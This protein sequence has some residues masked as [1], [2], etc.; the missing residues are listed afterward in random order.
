M[1]VFYHASPV[2]G[3]TVLKPSNRTKRRRDDPPYVY[4]ARSQLIAVGFM[5]NELTDEWSR[6]GSWDGRKTWW[7]VIGDEARFRE[8]ERRG[9]SLYT[10]PTDGFAYDPE[11]GL[12]DKEFSTASPVLVLH[13]E[14]WDSALA[15]MLHY[16]HRVLFMSKCLFIEFQG[17]PYQ[18]E[19]IQQAR[20]RSDG[21]FVLP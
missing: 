6:G 13:E 7:S 11:I 19:L 8:L 14:Q 3:L 1:N 2:Q 17:Y 15:A 10:V 20:R 12:G 21:T 4:A 18:W 9:G 16:G 5:V